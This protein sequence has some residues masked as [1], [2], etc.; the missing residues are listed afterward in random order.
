MKRPPRDS[1]DTLA[2]LIELDVTPVV[3]WK[4]L[5]G[6][7]DVDA[8]A[9]DA[10]AEF[11]ELQLAV[12]TATANNAANVAIVVRRLILVVNV[13]SPPS[14]SLHRVTSVPVI[15]S[16][17]INVSDD[18]RSV[19]SF[20][21]SQSTAASKPSVASRTLSAGSCFSHP[22]AAKRKRR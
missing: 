5:E 7:C 20:T 12:P 8:E 10:V 22:I 2:T 18:H 13:N 1:V 15:S 3:S 16:K 6:I 11:V 14:Q 21:C 19:D 4:A 9:V 17:A